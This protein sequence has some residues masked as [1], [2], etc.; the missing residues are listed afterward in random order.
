MIENPITLIIILVVLN[1]PLY[2][3]IGWFLFRSWEGFGEAIRYMLTPDILSLFWGE[4]CHDWWAEFR[5]GLLFTS[6]ALA[7]WGE[8]ILLSP[9][10]M[11]AATGGE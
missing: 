10:L 11:A 8:F 5:L 4:Y 6:S 3:G 7:I 2:V 9:Y 1:T